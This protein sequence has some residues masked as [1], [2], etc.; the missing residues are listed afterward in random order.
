MVNAVRLTARDPLRLLT[1]LRI[2]ELVSGDGGHAARH[3]DERDNVPS[4]CDRRLRPRGRRLF[5][6]AGL[7][8]FFQAGAASRHRAFRNH[9][10]RRRRQD[11]QRTD[12]PHA[13]R[14]G[15]ADRSTALG[16][17][18]AQRL[19][20]RHG[21]ARSDLDRRQPGGHAAQPGAG[22]TAAGAAAAEAGQAGEKAGAEKEDDGRRKARRAEACR[23]ARRWPHRRNR[24]PLRPGR[25][26]PPQR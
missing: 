12:L 5:V 26:R 11:L 21:N 7:V 17:L 20:A 8:E 15:A 4:H 2:L 13:L 25:R 6:D 18:H 16:H 9:P 19:P 24:R 22:R 23:R 10:A 14:A 1:W 3:W